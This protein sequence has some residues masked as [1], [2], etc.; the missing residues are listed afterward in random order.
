MFKPSG[1]RITL[2]AVHKLSHL[3]ID[4]F[5]P[6]P[7]PLLSFYW[8][9]TAI[10]ECISFIFWEKL[11]LNNFFFL[12]LTDLCFEHFLISDYKLYQASVL[13]TYISKLFLLPSLKFHNR[14][15]PR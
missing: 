14:S 4:D 5:S 9:R 1:K 2:D 13:T 6:P 10:F 3:K 15:G 12:R 11:Q 8:V 7:S